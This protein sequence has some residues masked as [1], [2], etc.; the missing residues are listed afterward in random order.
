MRPKDK[1]ILYY[2]Y[3]KRLVFRNSLNFI[4][5]DEIEVT[6][7][8]WKRYNRR[9]CRGDCANS[10]KAHTVILH[11]V[12]LILN[13]PFPDTFWY[14]VVLIKQFYTITVLDFS[15]IQTRFVGVEGKHADH[16][17]MAKFYILICFITWLKKSLIQP[18]FKV[19]FCYNHNKWPDLLLSAVLT[20]PCSKFSS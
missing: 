8:N 10:E 5:C 12:R 1:Y 17:T 9:R 2:V 18:K 16:L 6:R 7:Q 11:W 13:G 15:G 3:C 14:I 19:R 20:S 4:E